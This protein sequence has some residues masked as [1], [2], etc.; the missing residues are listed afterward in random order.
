M[1]AYQETHNVGLVCS[2]QHWVFDKKKKKD[3]PAVRLL[4]IE[5]VRFDPGRTGWTR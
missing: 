5:N 1:G 3:E 2:Y 4:P